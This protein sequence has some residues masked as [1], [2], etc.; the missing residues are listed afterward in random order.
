MA[1]TF[2]TTLAHPELY[3]MSTGRRQLSLRPLSAFNYLALI[4][5]DDQKVTGSFRQIYAMKFG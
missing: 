4:G 2:V 1:D 5:S 3:L